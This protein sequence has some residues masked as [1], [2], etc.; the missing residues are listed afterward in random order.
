MNIGHF[1]I[2]MRTKLRWPKKRLDCSAI[3]VCSSSRKLFFSL[4]K[5]ELNASAVTTTDTCDK[6]WK[7]QLR[8]RFKTAG[9]VNL[10]S[11]WWFLACAIVMCACVWECVTE[12]A[13]GIRST[14]R[15]TEGSLCPHAVPEPACLP[16]PRCS[17]GWFAFLL[18]IP[19]PVRFL[20]P[21]AEPGSKTAAPKLGKTWL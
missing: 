21:A 9:L 15:L 5:Q 19:L 8:K 14:S 3:Q 20:T 18:L 10:M 13:T 1:D 12:Y 11:V 17:S 4:S 16:K 6:C 2:T 7:E